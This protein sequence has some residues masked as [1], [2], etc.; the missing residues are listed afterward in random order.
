MKESDDPYIVLAYNLISISSQRTIERLLTDKEYILTLII[1]EVRILDMPGMFL[2][3]I[4]QS[5]LEDKERM[6]LMHEL[7][8]LARFFFSKLDIERLRNEI[9]KICTRYNIL[10]V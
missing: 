8:K 3:A 2:D 9:S 7:D 4:T 5:I 6:E 10:E 1:K